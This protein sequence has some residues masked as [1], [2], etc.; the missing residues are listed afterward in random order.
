MSRQSVVDAF[1]E[2]HF[3]RSNDLEHGVAGDA[4]IRT[5]IGRH[6]KAGAAGRL[7]AAAPR[8]VGRG[9]GSRASEICHKDVAPQ[10]R[11]KGPRSRKAS[12]ARAPN[13]PWEGERMDT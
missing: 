3:A 7:G 1:G 12:W 11:A 9:G 13:S 5:V 8:F 6:T 10:A 2:D 4:R